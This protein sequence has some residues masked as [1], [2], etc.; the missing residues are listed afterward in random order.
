MESRRSEESVGKDNLLGELKV[1]R[2][3]RAE[4]HS[5]I[6]TVSE[7][8][9]RLV[10]AEVKNITRSMPNVYYF[11]DIIQISNSIID[12]VLRDAKK[13]ILDR[14]DTETTR[15]ITEL[16]F[17]ICR[18]RKISN[19]YAE[20]INQGTVDKLEKFRKYIVGDDFPSDSQAPKKEE[21]KAWTSFPLFDFFS[22]WNEVR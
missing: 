22:G 20:A 1:F 17:E 7:L 3:Q 4:D 10:D 16:I 18:L 2:K 12:S 9:D 5:V 11:E 21:K 19:D 15:A 13:K 6:S 14:R 8:R